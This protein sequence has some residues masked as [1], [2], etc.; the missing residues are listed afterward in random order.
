[1]PRVENWRTKY[2]RQWKRLEKAKATARERGYTLPTELLQ[3]QHARGGYKQAFERIKPYTLTKIQRL[4]TYSTPEGIVPGGRIMAQARQRSRNIYSNLGE[5]YTIQKARSIVSPR[6]PS[7]SSISGALNEAYES[8]K[9]KYEDKVAQ[10]DH[11]KELEDLYVDLYRKEFGGLPQVIPSFDK[12]DGADSVADFIMYQKEQVRELEEQYRELFEGTYGA[13]PR[14]IPTMFPS[15]TVET[16]Y[17]MMRSADASYQREAAEDIA[18]LQAQ[19]MSAQD[20]KDNTL[21]EVQYMISSFRNRFLR[22]K[23]QDKFI[24]SYKSDPEG[25]INRI[26]DAKPEVIARL[27]EAITYEYE[28]DFENHPD[29][30]SS[31]WYN[32]WT[33]FLTG[34][35]SSE[36]QL[37]Y[38]ESEYE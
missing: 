9:K 25:T 10:Y 23:V 8:F 17:N 15:Y 19:V 33:D 34:D 1:M 35:Y 13:P 28:G 14:S 37:D 12:S 5:F 6:T 36:D 21:V 16:L 24:E 26:L 7:P 2:E 30:Q 38:A 31:R 20:V 18:K 4:S 32:W 11:S 22:Y 3:I 29:S 27:Q